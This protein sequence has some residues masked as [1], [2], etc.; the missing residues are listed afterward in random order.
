[1]NSNQEFTE[2]EQREMEIA[3]EKVSKVYDNIES[4]KKQL[5]NMGIDEYIPNI[6][7][8]LQQ[9]IANIKNQFNDRG[10]SIFAYKKDDNIPIV[11]NMWGNF[12][13]LDLYDRVAKAVETINMNNSNEQENGRAT[14]L[15]LTKI[16]PITKIFAK[17]KSLFGKKIFKSEKKYIQKESIYE[18]IRADKDLRK[19]NLD[20]DLI[21]SIFRGIEKSKWKSE[22]EA[23]E[24]VKNIIEPDLVRLGLSEKIAEIEEH[25]GIESGNKD[26]NKSQYRDF[27]ERVD[28][29]FA[30]VNNSPSIK[31]ARNEKED[32][33]ESS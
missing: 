11:T 29:D 23:K 13:L 19:Y 7:E 15:R 26:K 20:K 33:R 17:I 16:N 27:V 4:I 30:N 14:E 3:S 18:Y 12:I 10:I 28:I 1:M 8:T 6:G 25:F 9:V 5:E 22:D 31:N 32:E 21:G 2:F 24:F